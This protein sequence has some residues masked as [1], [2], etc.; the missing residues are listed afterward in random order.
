MAKPI[1]TIDPKGFAKRLHEA[2]DRHPDVFPPGRGRTQA[3]TKHFKIKQPTA[4]AWLT[5]SHMP[6]PEKVLEMAIELNQDFMRLYFGNAAEKIAKSSPLKA[7]Q[8]VRYDAETLGDAMK[9]LDEYFAVLGKHS[10]ARPDPEQLAIACEVIASG[11][12]EQDDTNVV[13]LLAKKLRKEV[14]GNGD[15]K[16]E[17]AG[18][19]SGARRAHKEAKAS[20]S[21]IR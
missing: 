17:D 18:T 12:V 3:V 7:S 9:L 11:G 6:A 4:T 13:V 14:G 5:G 19:G 1:P 16:G 8:M 21:R 20:G 15:V 10:P 2:L